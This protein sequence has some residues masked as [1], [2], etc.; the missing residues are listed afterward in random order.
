[1]E[2]QAPQPLSVTPQ[3]E[4][5]GRPSSLKLEPLLPFVPTVPVTFKRRLPTLRSYPG[6]AG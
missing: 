6:P 4:V 1:M 2:W 3:P 5:L